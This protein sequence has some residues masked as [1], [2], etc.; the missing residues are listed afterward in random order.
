MRVKSALLASSAAVALLWAMPAHA[1]G[2][3][4]AVGGG[5]NVV[6]DISGP[7]DF[8]GGKN[9][10][11]SLAIGNGAAHIEVENGFN[12][13]AALG[14]GLG[15]WLHGLTFETQAGYSRNDADGLW[16]GTGSPLIDVGALATTGGP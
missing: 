2:F 11:N 7:F 8:F 15:N 16:S 5:L 4:V 14:F 9:D 1:D 13:T 3:Y 6:D 12:L 10:I